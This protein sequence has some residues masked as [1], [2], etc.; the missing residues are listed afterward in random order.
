M[1]SRFEVVP[2]RDLMLSMPNNSSSTE[3]MRIGLEVVA[4]DSI[5]N[6]TGDNLERNGLESARAGLQSG[7][8]VEIGS[9]LV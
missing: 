7:K 2:L 4:F 3:G 5:K 9:A 6:A 8:P 1:N